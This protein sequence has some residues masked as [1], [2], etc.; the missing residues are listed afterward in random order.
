MKFNIWC[1]NITSFIIAIS[2]LFY[3]PIV[4]LNYTFTFND[5]DDDNIPFYIHEDVPD[6]TD[7]SRFGVY[8]W[9][10]ATDSL[11]IFFLLLPAINLLVL[12]YAGTEFTLIAGIFLAILFI[13][14]ILKFIWAF[15]L[16]I[17]D[18]CKDHQFCRNFGSRQDAIGEEVGDNEEN[19]NFVYSFMTWY[20]L[21]FLPIAIVYLVILGGMNRQFRDWKTEH[22]AELRIE[23][24]SR[25]LYGKL[26]KSWI[27]WTSIAL[28]STLVLVMIFYFPL[29]FLNFTFTSSDMTSKIVVPSVSKIN[30]PDNRI[31]FYINDKL[32]DFTELDSGR[33]ELYW[34]VYATDTFL[35]L[36]PVSVLGTIALLIYSFRDKPAKPD[37][38]RTTQIFLLGLLFLQIIK[39]FWAAV[40]SL[41]SLC[42]KH[43]FCRAFCSREIG[44]VPTCNRGNL[45]FVYSSLVWFNLVFCFL[46]FFQFLVVS[47]MEKAM[48]KTILSSFLPRFLTKSSN[49]ISTRYQNSV[50]AFSDKFYTT[51]KRNNG[52]RK[53]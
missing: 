29:V 46:L 12:R 47:S 28:C 49:N 11:R 9:I 45:N 39:F 50:N 40:L 18:N 22:K 4:F 31:P 52:K 8:W 3:F 41:P 37:F 36:V 33:L 51:I 48:F 26:V 13:W 34:W 44:G 6:H 32:T 21:A 2:L 35:I 53:K 24:M 42:E 25:T 16:W 10:Y 7:S 30:L 38:T 5:L 17:S 43:Q 23:K 27:V 19:Q 1:I 15:I 20:N 14:E